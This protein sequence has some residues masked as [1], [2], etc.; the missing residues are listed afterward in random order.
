MQADQDGQ[1]ADTVGADDGQQL[2]ADVAKAESAAS[3][4]EFLR[5]GIRETMPQQVAEQLKSVKCRTVE[6]DGSEIT[7]LFGN[8]GKG[9]EDTLRLD[10]TYK[11]GLLDQYVSKEYGYLDALS[12]SI[13]E[14]WHDPD[15]TEKDLESRSIDL[16]Q[17]FEKAF[18]KVSPEDGSQYKKLK[19]PA[20]YQ[21]DETGES[22]RLFK[23]TVSG[24]TYVVCLFY[25]MVVKYDAAGGR[26]SRK[27]AVKI[28]YKDYA[29]PNNEWE[30]CNIPDFR[31]R[32]MMTQLMDAALTQPEDPGYET[33]R[34]DYQK[35]LKSQKECGFSLYYK[36]KYWAAY[37]G[38]YLVG[39]DGNILYS[40]KLSSFSGAILRKTVDFSPV[41]PKDFSGIS[42]ASLVY[43]PKEVPERDHKSLKITDE[44][45]LA[46]IEQAFSH[47]EYVRG[48]SDCPMGEIRLWL[49]RSKIAKKE[50][51]V[52][53]AGDGCPMFRVG[54]ITY[55]Y[56]DS[57]FSDSL[58]KKLHSYDA[59]DSDK[60]VQEDKTDSKT[61]VRLVMT[62]GGREEDELSP[63][64]GMLTGSFRLEACQNGKITGKKAVNFGD[65]E[66][67]FPEKVKI[68]MKDYNGDGRADFALGQ[69]AGSNYKEYQFYTVTE[70]GKIEKL[71]VN[72]EKSETLTASS[73]EYS[74]AFRVKDGKVQFEYYDMENGKYVQSQAVIQ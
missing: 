45:E 21:G 29:T 46:M 42:E 16:I 5:Q 63:Y 67:Y 39:E 30:Y 9:G 38:G 49:Y 31:E 65:E 14:V 25:D 36:G 35:N 17:K 48:G 3:L 71:S 68:H 60:L 23:N 27:N 18:L 12:E 19:T 54:G 62:K 58:K 59:T 43:V 2:Q 52:T 70:A 57:K 6:G 73:A 69:Q 13:G 7:Y 66:L 53:L 55:R 44:K 4:E 24:D 33:L 26:F 40:A 28:A 72:G 41:K 51:I 56:D 32:K 74:P 64:H 47:A 37:D 8:G 15:H 50:L 34:V 61:T 10:F 20:R 1:Q 22:Y 11:D